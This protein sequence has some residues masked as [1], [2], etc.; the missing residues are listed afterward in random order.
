LGFGVWGLF[1]GVWGFGVFRGERFGL[2]LGI[3]VF[4]GFRVQVVG[5]MVFNL[6]LR[7]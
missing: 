3:R 2:E 7:V 6:K 1:G 4:S 5:F